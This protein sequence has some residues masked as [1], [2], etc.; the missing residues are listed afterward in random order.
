ML[1]GAA[2]EA[3]NERITMTHR[4]YHAL[5]PLDISCRHPGRVTEQV[6]TVLIG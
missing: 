1:I 6:G 5:C 3:E 4:K 2:M